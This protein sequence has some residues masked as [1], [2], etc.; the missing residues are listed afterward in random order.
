MSIKE[1]NK[2]SENLIYFRKLRKMSQTDVAQKLGIPRTRYAK[3]ENNIMPPVSILENIAK[4]Y[5]IKLDTLV[6]TVQHTTPHKKSQGLTIRFE[7]C[8][9]PKPRPPAKK[10]KPDNNK[11]NDTEEELWKKI[12]ELPASGKRKLYMRIIEEIEG[13]REV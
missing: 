13:P 12:C 4:I 10:Y 11:L 2:L 6:R 7:D 3:Y 5:D 8:Y 1:K 9:K